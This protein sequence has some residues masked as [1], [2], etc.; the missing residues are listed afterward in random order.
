[1]AQSTQDHGEAKHH[2]W[3][4]VAKKAS[5]ASHSKKEKGRYY[6]GAAKIFVP[7]FGERSLISNGAGKSSLVIANTAGRLNGGVGSGHQSG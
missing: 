3:Y 7:L 4:L 1:M 5:A 6:H 2:G